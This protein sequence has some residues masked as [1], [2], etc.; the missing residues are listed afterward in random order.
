MDDGAQ[1][2]KEM[3]AMLRKAAEDG[4]GRIVATPHVTPGVRRFNREQYQ[5]SL[6]EARSYCQ[7]NDLD[8][9]LYEGAE[10]L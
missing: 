4:I 7:E 3:H 1:N 6:E 8:I 9:A 10:I 5:R 2:P